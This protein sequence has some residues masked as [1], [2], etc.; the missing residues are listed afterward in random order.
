[1]RVKSNEILYAL[2]EGLPE[3]VGE[4][5][6]ELLLEMDDHIC[7]LFSIHSSDL[8]IWRIPCGLILPNSNCPAK[9][10][11]IPYTTWASNFG[12]GRGTRGRIPGFR[13]ANNQKV[14]NPTTA[15]IIS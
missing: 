4:L 10:N 3:E 15:P 5:H 9:S 1:L 14:F 11:K 13:S 12:R 7:D 2:E 8:D 6:V